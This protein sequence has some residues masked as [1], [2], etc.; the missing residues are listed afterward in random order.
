[1]AE[2]FSPRGEAL[3]RAAHEIAMRRAEDPRTPL[4]QIIGE[5]ARHFDLSPSE[6]LMLQA[7][8]LR[9]GQEAPP[10]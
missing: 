7:D 10:R 3:R 6:E 4:V 8:L 2:D 5:A 1:M 9:E